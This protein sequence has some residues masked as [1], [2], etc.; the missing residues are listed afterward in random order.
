M[1][2]EPWDDRLR[3]IAG[4]SIPT[5]TAP[6]VGGGGFFLSEDMLRCTQ[7]ISAA[8][9]CCILHW[10]YFWACGHQT[11]TSCFDNDKNIVLF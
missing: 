6:S 7:L 3:I 4:L 11:L 9:H 8:K 5:P 1:R 2:K 10:E